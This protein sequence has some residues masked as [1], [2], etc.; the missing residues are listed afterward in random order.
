M[1]LP[2]RLC[3]PGK[4]HKGVPLFSKGAMKFAG[5]IRKF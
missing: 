2:P 4:A 1:L 5:L 3:G